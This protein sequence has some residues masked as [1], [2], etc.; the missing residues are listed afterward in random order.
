MTQF[1]GQTE[2]VEHSCGKHRFL[3]T[4]VTEVPRLKSTGSS[5][6]ATV[7]RP[8]V[9]VTKATETGTTTRPWFNIHIFIVRCIRNV[10]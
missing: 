9:T 6:S 4:N 10:S 3:H 2:A 8:E 1:H 5:P 7:E